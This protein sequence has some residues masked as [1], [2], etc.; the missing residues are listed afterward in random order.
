MG[1]IKTFFDPSVEWARNALILWPAGKMF[2]TNA[3]FLL[4]F[5]R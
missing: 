4:C 5:E 3:G 1:Q 2:G